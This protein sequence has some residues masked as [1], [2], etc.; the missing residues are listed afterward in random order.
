MRLLLMCFSAVALSSLKNTEVGP[1]TNLI[2]PILNE[3][4]HTVLNIDEIK[5]NIVK[6]LLSLQALAFPYQS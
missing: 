1:E 5:S 6:K 2:G 4:S 3:L